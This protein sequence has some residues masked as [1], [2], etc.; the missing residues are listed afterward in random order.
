MLLLL[1]TRLY[2]SKQLLAIDSPNLYN[3]A[4]KWIFAASENLNPM[5]VGPHVASCLPMGSED[6]SIRAVPESFEWGNSIGIRCITL[7]EY[8]LF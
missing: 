4:P 7:C 3:L 8:I 2:G 5:S 1:K 6:I